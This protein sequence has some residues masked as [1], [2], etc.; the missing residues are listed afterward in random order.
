MDHLFAAAP[1]DETAQQPQRLLRFCR[2]ELG[3]VAPVAARNQRS[4]AEAERLAVRTRQRRR[5]T[6]RLVGRQPLER[7]EKGA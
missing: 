5:D 7:L 4:H 3:T 1:A 6:A 2:S